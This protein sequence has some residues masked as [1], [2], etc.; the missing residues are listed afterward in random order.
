MCTTRSCQ[1][2]VSLQRMVSLLVLEH[3]Y[4]W[5]YNWK[6]CKIFWRLFPCNSSHFCR[7]YS[8]IWES[9]NLGTHPETRCNL[10]VGFPLMVFPLSAVNHFRC[11][12]G[13]W[14]HFCCRKIF[15]LYRIYRIHFIRKI[16]LLISKVDC[17][18]LCRLLAVSLLS[19]SKEVVIWKRSDL[20]Y[21]EKS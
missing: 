6:F 1:V 8:W 7:T 20:V 14:M 2:F 5:L 12:T 11:L 15:S 3:F 9:R 4:N 17:I 10:T 16:G 13:F 18:N 19:K 21:L